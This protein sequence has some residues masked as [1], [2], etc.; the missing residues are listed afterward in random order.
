MA[1]AQGDLATATADFTESL[2]IFQE[3]GDPAIIWS[4]AGLGSVAALGG[5]PERA[6]HLWG[7]VEALRRDQWQARYAA[8]RATY[9]RAVAAAR[10]Q[11]GADAFAA[12]WAAGRTMTLE[13]ALAYA[14]EQTPEARISGLA[15]QA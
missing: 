15:H 1:L 5:Q 10:A 6:A 12:A 9:E 4:L 14:L 7:A 2:R 11:V 3:M 13:Q 8:S